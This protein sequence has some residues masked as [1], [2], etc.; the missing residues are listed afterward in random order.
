MDPQINLEL[1][2]RIDAPRARVWDALTRDTAV[3]FGREADGGPGNGFTLE[4]HVGGRFFR[5]LRES[6]GEGM[7]H[8]WGHVQVIK[9]PHL[10]EISGPLACS[11]PA[12]N[13][14]AFRLSEDGDAT[15]VSFKH[16]GLGMFPEDFLGGFERGWRSL[17]EEGLKKHVEQHN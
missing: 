9:P 3:W 4:A 1:E 10:L 13:H 15:L 6:H 2:T 14:V 8:L 11:M 17:L 7:G 12:L 16:V 5:H